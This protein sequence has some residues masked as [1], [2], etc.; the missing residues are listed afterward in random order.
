MAETPGFEPGVP[1][2]GHDGLANRWFQPLTHVSAY[3]H[4]RAQETDRGPIAAARALGNGSWL[5]LRRSRFARADKRGWRRSQKLAQT[6]R[7]LLDR[8]N[9]SLYGRA[10][11]RGLVLHSDVICLARSVR[12]VL[13]GFD[14]LR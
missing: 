3:D 7:A 5:R 12:S 14:A 11:S 13:A 10:F 2:S 1:H 4:P 9:D 8:V 6:G